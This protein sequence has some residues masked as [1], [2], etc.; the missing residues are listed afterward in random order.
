[1]IR[2]N[3]E[4]FHRC[5]PVGKEFSSIPVKHQETLTYHCWILPKAGKFATSCSTG[6]NWANENEASRHGIFPWWLEDGV[7]RT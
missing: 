5:P 6:L 2:P 7:V 3:P 4:D 1:M